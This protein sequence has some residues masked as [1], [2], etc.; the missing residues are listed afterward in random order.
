MVV[1][2]CGSCD[3]T[4]VRTDEPITCDGCKRRYHGK[5][6]TLN[7]NKLT[8]LKHS[9]HLKWFCLVCPDDVDNIL[10]NFEKFLKVSDAIEKMKIE[11]E[12]RFREIEN[13]LAVCETRSKTNDVK[14]VVA[15][16][17]NKN[18]LKDTE[19][20]AL[21]V[22]KEKKVIYFGIPETSNDSA[23]ERMKHD[24]KRLEEAYGQ[25]IEHTE[26]L[27]MFRVGK[28]EPNK[29]RPLVIKF[30]DIELKKNYLKKSG[31]LKIKHGNE[32]IPVY[33]SIDRTEKQH[34]KHK[35]LVT[36]LKARKEAGEQNLVIRGE[37]I[38]ENFQKDTSAQKVTWISLFQ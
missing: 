22:A 29:T 30:S 35:K 11:N 14:K 10:N 27:T 28:K 15:E 25:T 23:A 24:Y 32:I 13:R 19:E 37:K 20:S 5:C 33:A 16:E 6:T 3:K 7:D 38:I 31:D 17:I 8:I 26:I 4:F 18:S 12:N 34:E 1:R 21:I 2:K 36:E 9:N